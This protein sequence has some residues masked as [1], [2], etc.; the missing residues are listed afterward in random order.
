MNL[1]PVTVLWVYIGFLVLGGLIGFLKAKSKI[2]LIM[3]LIFA[4]ALTLCQL[5]VLAAP[6]L[7]DI[8]LLLL[9][10]VFVI[11]LIKTRKFMP[12]GLMV[13]LTAAV[14]AQRHF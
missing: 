3:S 6:N 12:A 13:I 11:R 4:V 1:N 2:S 5:G 10:L 8:L 7:T 14:L 9:L